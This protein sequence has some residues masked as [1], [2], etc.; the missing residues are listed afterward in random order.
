MSLQ[1]ESPGEITERLRRVFSKYSGNR[2]DLIPLLQDIQDVAGYIPGEAMSET[3]RLLNIPESTVY[4]VV[5]FYTQFYLT[6]QGK[7]K[8]K[9]CQGTACRVSG[10]DRIMEAVKGRLGVEPGGTSEDFRFSL[11]PLVC[12]GCCAASPVMIVDG[13]VY[14]R[15]T[16]EKALQLLRNL[17]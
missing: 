16:A 15:M 5:T 17:E 12:S 13:K 6:R 3:A 10:A 2:G 4:G 14:G 7:H 8:V 1:L 9:V 11:E